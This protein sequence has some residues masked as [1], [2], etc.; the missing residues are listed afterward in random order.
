MEDDNLV[1]LPSRDRYH[2]TAGANEPARPNPRP[3]SNL[4]RLGRLM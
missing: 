1:T 2:A 4:G 3:I